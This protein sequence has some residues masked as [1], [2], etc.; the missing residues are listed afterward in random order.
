MKW[1]K[2]LAVACAVLSAPY[3]SAQ[4]WP[5]KPIRWIVPFSVGGS[6]DQITRYVTQRLSETLGTPIVVENVV[7]AGGAIGLEKLAKSAPDGYTFGTTAFSL[8]AIA[9]H[10]T[11][12]PYDTIQDFTA[13]APLTA[14]GYAVM[15][16]PESPIDS[17]TSLLERAKAAP[18]SI[19]IAS[20]GVG[21]GTHLAGVLFA[22][23]ANVSLNTVQYKGS[24]PILTDLIGGHVDLA[25]EVIGSAMPTINSGRTRP[26]ATTS[27][28][29]HPM[30]DKVPTL[31][32]VIPG[33]AI[34]GWFAAYG[35]AGL[36]A[37]VVSRLHKELDAIQQSDDYR[38]YLQARGYEAMRATPDELTARVRMELVKWEEVVKNAVLGLPKN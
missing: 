12:L 30:L 13:I 1:T 5:A 38:K 8:Q 4:T 17:L 33:L 31:S 27:A 29:R 37:D 7:G 16:R 34:E 36:P 6:T 26:I 20:P 10:V 19:S 23:Q 14:F 25:I 35:P 28:S 32:E 18:G 21:T 22:N 3:A 11:K 15:V 9:P 24:A 2:I